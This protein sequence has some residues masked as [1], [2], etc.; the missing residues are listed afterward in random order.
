MRISLTNATRTS[1]EKA[2]LSRGAV[3]SSWSSAWVHPSIAPNTHAHRQHALFIARA[4]ATGALLLLAIPPMLVFQSSMGFF[5]LSVAAWSMTPF[6]LAYALSRTGRLEAVTRALH[7]CL[8]GIIATLALSSQGLASPFLLLLCVIPMEGALHG[9]R[10]GLA[11]NTVLAAVA[12]A[13]VALCSYNGF[14]GSP[15]PANVAWYGATAAGVLYA[16]VLALRLAA[17]QST[18]ALQI[19]SERERFRLIAENAADLVTKHSV[20]GEALFVSPAAKS[21]LGVPASDL[22]NKGFLDR[23]H[24]Q[25]RIAYLKA[26]SDA[27]HSGE[28]TVSL[29]LRT[30]GMKDCIW[31]PVTMT[32]RAQLCPRTGKSQLIAVTR[33][34][35]AL[36]T[37]KAEL[38]AQRERND[39][40]DGDRRRFITTMSH[41]LRTPLNAII[42]FSDILRQELFGALANEK[43]AEYV[44]LINESGEHL[45]QVVNEMLDLSRISAGKYELSITSFNVGNVVSATTGM[46]QTMAVKE[47][48]RVSATVADDLPQLRADRRA[49]QQILI[50]LVSNAIKFT[51]PQGDVRVHVDRYNGSMRF[52]VSDTGIGM[53]PDFIAR[54]GEPFLQADNGHD[55]HFE[56][57][58]LGLSVVKGLVDLHGGTITFDSRPDEGTTVTVCLPMRPVRSR[59]VPANGE[60]TMVRLKTAAPPLAQTETTKTIIGETSAR[61][62]A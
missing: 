22:L 45:L 46:L 36:T 2:A 40:A 29:R 44:S 15:I 60:N 51:P 37:V 53:Q 56:G 23:V 4:L 25:D 8:A 52:V 47:D 31:R 24:L 20:K 57:S 59:P 35:H 38:A 17:L 61:V 33:D 42:G 3:A 55:R 11:R 18:L 27:Y 7:I 26:F 49:C 62:S 54:I 32:V 16:V 5:S 10:R 48:V 13:L 34:R 14:Y 30:K 41:E 43:Q 12:I 58:G 9:G 28:C 39:K 50:N 1:A 21:L 6:V 19:G